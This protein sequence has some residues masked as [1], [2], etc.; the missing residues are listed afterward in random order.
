[1][2]E[3]FKQTLNL[4]Q[5]QPVQRMNEWMNEWSRGDD[6]GLGEKQNYNNK[7][8]HSSNGTTFHK[9]WD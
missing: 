2:E 4:V 9:I 7:N 3:M 5:K 6:E 1:M 8:V